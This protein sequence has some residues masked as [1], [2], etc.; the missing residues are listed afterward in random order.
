LAPAESPFEQG[1]RAWREGCVVPHPRP[2]DDYST[3]LRSAGWQAARRQELQEL[4][5]RAD[6]IDPRWCADF[7]ERDGSEEELREFV[8]V[9]GHGQKNDQALRAHRGEGQ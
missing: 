5:E 9:N 1:Q 8:R 4:A 7:C 3:R 6:R 2:D